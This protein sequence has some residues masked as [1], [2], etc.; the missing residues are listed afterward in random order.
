MKLETIYEYLK[1]NGL[2]VSWNYNYTAIRLESSTVA[3]TNLLFLRVYKRRDSSSIEVGSDDFLTISIVTRRDLDTLIDSYLEA[4][5]I[6]H[7]DL[8]Q[9]KTV[10]S[11]RLRYAID[12]RKRLSAS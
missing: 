9:A 2:T 6:E 5:S 3:L 11:H 10:R 4:S 1:M 8:D 12:R 7:C